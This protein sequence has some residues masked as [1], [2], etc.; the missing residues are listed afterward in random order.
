MNTETYK[1]TSKAIKDLNELTQLKS[2]LKRK[3][4]YHK[5]LNIK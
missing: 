1:Q 3:K 4:T 2:Q 5:T